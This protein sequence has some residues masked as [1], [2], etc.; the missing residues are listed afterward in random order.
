ER[1]RASDAVDFGDLLLHTVNLLRRAERPKEGQLAD[2]DPMLHLARRFQHIVVDEFQ[3][4]NPVQ[5]ELV[6]RLATRAE[7][8]VVG[9]DDQSIYGWRGADVAQILRFADRH[10]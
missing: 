9:D 5:A 10:P 8:C 6:D 1:L 2:L 7:L 4:T 3:D